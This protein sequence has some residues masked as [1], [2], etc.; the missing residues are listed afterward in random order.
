MLRDANVAAIGAAV[1]MTGDPKPLKD[2]KRQLENGVESDRKAGGLDAFVR[3]IASSG[4]MK[5][6]GGEPSRVGN[7]R[8]TSRRT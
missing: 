5:V 4:K 8:R 2:L 3:R 7:R 1:G 6:E